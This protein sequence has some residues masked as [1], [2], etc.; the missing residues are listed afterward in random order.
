MNNTTQLPKPKLISITPVLWRENNGMKVISN[1]N[2]SVT[3]K[4][5]KLF[6]N[7]EVLFSYKENVSSLNNSVLLVETLDLDFLSSNK[8]IIMD[9]MKHV[10]FIIVSDENLKML[11]HSVPELFNMNKNIIN[12]NIIHDYF[13]NL[14]SP[15]NGKL[16][17]SLI[18]FSII[19]Q[20]KKLNIDFDFIRENVEDS[21]Q[22]C[23]TDNGIEICNK[24]LESFWLFSQYYVPKQ[25]ER[26]AEILETLKK[27][28][29][30][31]LIDKIILF[32][33]TDEDVANLQKQGLNLEKVQLINH[34]KRLSYSDFFKYVS[35]DEVPEN[36]IVALANSDIYF[37]STLL[38]LW[39]LNFTEKCLALLRW[40]HSEEGTDHA[41][42][43]G[44]RPDSQDT[45]IFHAHSIKSRAKTT[46]SEKNYETFNYYLGT[47]GCDNSFTT[48]V[49][50]EKFGVFNPAASIKTYHIHGSQIR[51]YTRK[52]LVYRPV[53]FGVNP[54]YIMEKNNEKNLPGKPYSVSP[55][56]CEINLKSNTDARVAT[57]VTMLARGKRYEWA[58]PSST[59]PV[60]NGFSKSWKI[61]KISGDAYSSPTGLVSNYN[62]ILLGD[63]DTKNYWAK[64][65]I[66][67]YYRTIE[68]PSFL[69]IAVENT[70]IF[71]NKSAFITHY[72]G[73]L[74]RT[75]QEISRIGDHPNALSVFWPQEFLDIADMFKFPIKLECVPW[76]EHMNVY[77]KC[78]FMVPGGYVE[79]CQ[80]TIHA[81]R[82][83]LHQ[84]LPEKPSKTIVVLTSSA[85]LTPEFAEKISEQLKK[86]SQKHS[87]ESEWC[88]EIYEQTNPPSYKALQKAGG[89]IFWGDA[90]TSE[91]WMNLWAL[92]PGSAMLEF[93]NEFK[94]DGEAQQ[95]GAA[96]GLDT[97]IFIL[98]K[99]DMQYLQ[100]LAMQ[101]IKDY[102]TQRL[103]AD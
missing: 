73:P 65:R 42:I 96:C 25:K 52:D 76:N 87:K 26:Q 85:V 14:G 103:E 46:W 72:V 69:A 21:R 79:V 74:L 86:L 22:K 66:N 3:N 59:V 55:Y 16:E 13:Q 36:T 30:N 54:T 89:I 15:W 37:D 75:L 2:T 70:N 20:Y 92:P 102:F 19:N 67:I 68:R 10:N 38:N 31:N 49:I 83:S 43:L 90:N 53:Y 39:S 80:E 78:M 64:S 24:E 17:D 6:T 32:T 82:S 84:P 50:R 60:K 5:P 62:N 23:M 11:Q 27:N 48:D 56:S 40:E 12:L 81:L 8:N 91:R 88:C 100:D 63:I 41:K 4:I 45:W 44:P 58:P 61:W 93:Q 7:L 97:R 51:T 34:K 95:M 33:E 71:T 57:Y 9:T 99:A 35:T 18:I 94:L 47:P 98:Q 77:S 1:Q 29:A 28:V 101:Y